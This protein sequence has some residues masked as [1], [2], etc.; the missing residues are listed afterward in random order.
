M[1]E[2]LMNEVNARG[3]VYMSH[4]KLAEK[5]TLRLAIG[6]IRTSREHIRLAWDELNEVLERIKI[7]V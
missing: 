5:L 4:T 1:N 3:K 2:R 6:N 7:E